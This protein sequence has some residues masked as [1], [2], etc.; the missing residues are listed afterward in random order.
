MRLNLILF[1][2]MS[3]F[4]QKCYN[5]MITG[6]VQDISFRALVEDI[7]R[8]YDLRGFVFND[9]DGS[10]KMV[11]CGDNGNIADFL[12]ELK[13]K[14]NLRG[15]HVDDIESEEIPFEIYLPQ[16]FLRLYTDDLTD[17]SR[18]LDKG[19][20]L[21]GDIKKD[22]SAL[23]EIKNVLNSFIGEQRDHNQSM[24]E[25]NQRIDEHNQWMKEHNQR[26]ENILVKLAEK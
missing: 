11:C 26:L 1:G 4:M 2:Y 23:P 18:K 22:T 24:K 8:L 20:D 3:L 5:L 13:I 15:A 6:K 21:L 16:R 12:E 19:N 10:V 9:L 7:A 25:H 17:I 14:G